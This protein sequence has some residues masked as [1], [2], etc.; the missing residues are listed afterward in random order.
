MA[1]PSGVEDKTK[2]IITRA[3][4]LEDKPDVDFNNPS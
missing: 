3:L 1:W 2:E 4:P